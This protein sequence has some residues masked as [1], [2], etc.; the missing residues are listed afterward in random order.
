MAT[1][2]VAVRLEVA[3]ARLGAIALTVIVKLA[4][5]EPPVLEAVIV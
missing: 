5:A 3:K 4:E 2:L 1:S